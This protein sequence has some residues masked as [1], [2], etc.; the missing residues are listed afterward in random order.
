[1]RFSRAMSVLWLLACVA[2][3]AHKGAEVFA[4]RPETWDGKARQLN[5]ADRYTAFR[6]GVIKMEP[7]AILAGPMADG[8]KDVGELILTGNAQKP[9][10]RVILASLNVYD[11]MKRKGTWNLCSDPQ[12]LSTAHQQEALISDPLIKKRYGSYLSNICHEE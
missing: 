8:G 7:P 11:L 9:D 6:Y 3:C 5:L 12:H 4:G 1:M 2:G 10:D